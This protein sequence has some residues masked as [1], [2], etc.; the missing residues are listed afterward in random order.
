MTGLESRA[1]VQAQAQRASTN[2]MRTHSAGAALLLEPTPSASDVLRDASENQSVF[3]P[4]LLQP[5]T[6]RA[7]S[8]PQG[9]AVQQMHTFSL[10][11]LHME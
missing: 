9:G 4:D 3:R 6:S 10:S 8:I 11:D 5:P 2:T 1:Q 7:G